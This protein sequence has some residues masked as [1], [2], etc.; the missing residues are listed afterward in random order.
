M[1]NLPQAPC[2]HP[3]KVLQLLTFGSHNIKQ[4]YCHGRR[5]SNSNFAMWRKCLCYAFDFQVFQDS[6]ISWLHLYNSESFSSLP[7]KRFSYCSE[8]VFVNC[9]I[10]D[11]GAEILAIRLNP[12]VLEK[13]VL[14]FNRISDTGAVV[15]AWCI[16]R[17]SVVQEV[18]IQFN[19]IGDLGAIA[20][21]DALVHCSSLRRL[22]LQGNGLG[23][24]GAVA[25]AKATEGLPNLDLYLH[26]VNITEE[27]VERVLEHRASTKIRAMVF[28]SSWDAI[29]MAGIDAL[30]SALK[31]GTLPALEISSTNIY[32][33]E[34]LVA[35]LEHVR[36]I[37]R[38][39]SDWVTDDTLPKLC[40]IIKSMDNLQHLECSGSSSISFTVAQLLGDILRTCKFLYSVSL[41]G[42]IYGIVMEAVKCC[43]NLRSLDMTHCSIGSEG[44]TS[45]FCNYKSWVNLHTLNLG[46]N[47][48]G[49]DGAQVLSKVLVHCIYLRYL[50]LS[51]NDLS[52][53]GCLS[54]AEGLQNHTSLLELKLGGNN[55]TSECIAAMIPVI[56]RNH[57]Q[58]LDLSQCDIGSDDMAALVDVTCADTLQ[59][60]ELRSN[61]LSLDSARILS[62]GLQRC[63]QLME[64]DIS[65]NR[66]GSHDILY[67]AVGLKC[68]RQLVQLDI[69]YNDIGSYGMSF[70]ADGLQ[71]CIHL[72]VLNLKSNEITSDSIAA[73]TVIMKRCRYLQNLDL[74][75]NSIGVDGAAVLVG[76]WQ[77]K[78]MLIVD[79][80]SCLGK[81]HK[82]ALLNVER[83]CS[84]CDHLLELYYNND[85]VI[86][87]ITYNG[88]IPKL[89]SSS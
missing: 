88:W 36:N 75:E 82:S 67:L 4:L 69:S 22:D 18:S 89:V 14:D 26:N 17:C 30:R 79:L 83:C 50:D 40:G 6:D 56:K 27:G 71:H 47:K 61:S 55:I 44:V 64:L 86:I 48:I 59:T 70:L 37:R 53:S 29:D 66:I 21:A 15:L 49:S 23:D 25:I 20:L 38:L 62:D 11:E 12:A 63:R 77:H 84:G 28:G 45:L 60:L 72:Q 5:Y 65:Y 33:I 39:I 2:S 58:H 35:E 76:G 78:C 41:H 43:N 74:S 3:E 1:I 42:G 8:V 19:S 73:I 68:C 34:I 32:N 87:H 9:G 51:C 81:P 13:L 85:Y 24:E 10:D 16:A 46:G 31:C 7:Q 54:L 52:D 80:Q 57:L